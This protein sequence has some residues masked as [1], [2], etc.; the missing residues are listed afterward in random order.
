M[1]RNLNGSGSRLHL[2]IWK[3]GANPVGLLLSTYRRAFSSNEA[4]GLS[5]PSKPINSEN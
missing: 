1:W 5:P 3:P 2:R 4:A